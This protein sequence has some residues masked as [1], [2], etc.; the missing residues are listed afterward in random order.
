M[1]LTTPMLESLMS[2]E[3][4]CLSLLIFYSGFNFP[5]SSYRIMKQTVKLL[6]LRFFKPHPNTKVKVASTSDETLFGTN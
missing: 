1:Y 3:F 4:K 2:K 6:S 5:I